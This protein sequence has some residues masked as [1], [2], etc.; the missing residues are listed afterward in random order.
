VREVVP[1]RRYTET[2]DTQD[3]L[4]ETLDMQLWYLQGPMTSAEERKVQENA[5]K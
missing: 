5:V 1:S 2:L 3:T 4:T